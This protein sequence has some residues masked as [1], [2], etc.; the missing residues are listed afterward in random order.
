MLKEV[1]AGSGFRVNEP[2]VWTQPQSGPGTSLGPTTLICSTRGDHMTA[3]V[4]RSG[5]AGGA[6]CK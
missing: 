5:S 6:G 4:M 3:E 2:R 1:S